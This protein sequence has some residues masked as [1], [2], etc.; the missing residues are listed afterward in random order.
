MA[1]VGGV[2]CQIVRPNAP[3]GNK[4]RIVTWIVAGLTGI[5]AHKLG[6]NQADWS[7][8]LVKFG[9]DAQCDTWAAEI[10]A[11][12]ATIVTIID[13]FPDTYTGMLITGT[14]NKLKRPALHALALG[15]TGVRAEIT[16]SGQIS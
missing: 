12:Q 11:L 14:S 13:D 2:A 1:S 7:F 3:V 5:G 8:N 9:T 16:I 4:Q 10:E 15:L 6:V